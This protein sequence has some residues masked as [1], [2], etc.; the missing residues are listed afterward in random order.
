MLIRDVV[1]AV[2]GELW[3]VSCMKSQSVKRTTEVSGRI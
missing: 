3:A 1:C 2:G